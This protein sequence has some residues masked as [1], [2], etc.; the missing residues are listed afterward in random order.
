MQCNL[1]NRKEELSKVWGGGGEQK[2]KEVQGT[3]ECGF[4][5]WNPP[6]YPEWH[7]TSVRETP[8][9]AQA[10]PLTLSLPRLQGLA[11][12][13]PWLLPHFLIFWPVSSCLGLPCLLGVVH[14]N[15]FSRKQTKVTNH[16]AFWKR[17]TDAG[18]R[19]LL[20]T[21]VRRA[22]LSLKAELWDMHYH[23]V[24]SVQTQAQN[25]KLHASV[26]FWHLQGEKKKKDFFQ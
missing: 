7:C 3:L 21:P 14:A 8:Q 6:R 13:I 19:S 1:S 26:W 24:L 2:A 20:C 12:Y 11:T 5:L 10:S 16:T 23:S 9:L 17:L 18:D 22:A 15:M 4:F 25:P